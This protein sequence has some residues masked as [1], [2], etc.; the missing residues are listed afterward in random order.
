MVVLYS[1]HCPRCNCLKELLDKAGVSY[2]E[3]NDISVME[4]LGIDRTPMLKVEDGDTQELLKY[5]AAI[6]WVANYEKQRGCHV[7]TYLFSSSSNSRSGKSVT[8]R[9]LY[10]FSSMSP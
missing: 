1:N 6:K 9:K 8:Q 3:E 10:L 4:A 2:E 5:P 7:A